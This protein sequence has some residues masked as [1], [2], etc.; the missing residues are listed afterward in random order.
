MEDLVKTGRAKLRGV[1]PKTNS[2]TKRGSAV[3]STVKRSSQVQMGVYETKVE[4]PVADKKMLFAFALPE[5]Y[6][7]HEITITITKN[8][9]ECYLY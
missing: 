1:T 9:R 2:P 4:I 6:K 3:L 7:D 8:K 5:K